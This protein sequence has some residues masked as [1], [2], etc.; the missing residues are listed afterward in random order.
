[1][2]IA[3][4]VLRTE[5]HPGGA[6]VILA[7]VASASQYRLELSKDS[8]MTWTPLPAKAQ[9]TI[10]LSD[11]TNG[12]KVHVRGVAINAQRASDPS[13]EYPIYVTD[14]PPASPDGLHVDLSDGA[15][16]VSWGEVLGVSE[17][18]LFGKVNGDS[19]F[20]LLYH[21]LERSYRDMRPSIHSSQA[22]PGENRAD[23]SA[24]IVQY[25]VTA[26]NGNGASARSR[27]ADTNPASW[28]NWD[29]K[30]GEP[31]RRVLSYPPDSPP[32]ASEW[33]RY[34]PE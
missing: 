20:E 21:G 18:R 11:L 16:T 12:Q 22:A 24:I 28:R 17:Y 2:P 15:A 23:S 5:N 27:I 29:P 1:M 13:P 19:E 26:S 34:Y 30:P 33:P 25:Y 10:E 6:R 7:E 3:P 14:Q 31:F 4:V 9:S 8:G 32:S